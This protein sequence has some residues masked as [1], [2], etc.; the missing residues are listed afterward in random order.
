MIK[1]GLTGG[2]G[3]GKSIIAK[4]FNTLGIYVYN[5]DIAAKQIYHTNPDLKRK[6]IHHFGKNV[7]LE[8]G[9]LNKQ[10]LSKQIF[11]DKNKLAL[12]NSLVHPL[13]KADFANQLTQHKNS[14][15]IIKETA[16]LIESNIYKELDKVIVVTA[17]E[18]IRINRV[19]KR[20][21][22]SEQ[23]VV[24]RINNQLSDKERIKYADYLIK[25]DSTNLLIPQVLKIHEDL[26]RNNILQKNAK[27]Y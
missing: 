11:E 26:V 27:F 6:L 7:Y 18:N 15:Y 20:D 12:I 14:P 2:I 9:K 21:K 16:I 17:P 19:C 3:S 1:V 5:S 4:I 25:N 22:L 23:D 13:V 24:K 8:S 10:Y